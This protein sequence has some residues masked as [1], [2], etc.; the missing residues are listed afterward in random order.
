[1]LNKPASQYSVWNTE[2]TP[3]DVLWALILQDCIPL[4]YRFDGNG[5]ILQIIWL[6]ALNLSFSTTISLIKVLSETDFLLFLDLSLLNGNISVS[7]TSGTDLSMARISTD[8]T[9]Q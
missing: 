8:L 1:M 2:I 9:V 5:N 7:Q 3:T 6:G 4:I